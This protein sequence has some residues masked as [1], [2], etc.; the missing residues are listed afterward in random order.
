MR[1]SSEKADDSINLATRACWAARAGKHRVK[2]LAR[3]FLGRPLEQEL[4]LIYRAI[5]QVEINKVLIRHSQFVRH[6]LKIRHR[7]FIEP[8]RNRLFQMFNVGV[9]LSLHL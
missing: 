6:R 2:P 4:S 9:F 1:V 3:P 8:D 7:S 5:P